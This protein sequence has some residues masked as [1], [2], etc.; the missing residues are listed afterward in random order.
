ME[1]LKKEY[2]RY[3]VHAS[4][5]ADYNGAEPQEIKDKLINESS[6]FVELTKTS[7]SM[8]PDEKL[9]GVEFE[10]KDET[11]EVKITS[12]AI[13]IRV[14]RLS[15]FEDAYRFVTDRLDAEGMNTPSKDSYTLEG[16]TFYC[17]DDELGVT[18]DETKCTDK[19]YMGCLY[20]FQGHEFRYSGIQGMISF[21]PDSEAIPAVEAEEFVNSVIRDD[22]LIVGPIDEIEETDDE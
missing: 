20:E 21:V 11:V 19:N 15:I 6:P 8:W 3:D 1:Y 18:C 9:I 7:R 10:N 14:D 2:E 5:E 13:Q 17:E 12:S 22:I 4:F 16:M